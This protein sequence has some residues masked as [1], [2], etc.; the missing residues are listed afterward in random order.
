MLIVFHCQIGTIV[1]KNTD[2]EDL[3]STLS[4]EEWQRLIFLRSVGGVETPTT[5]E[6][7]MSRLPEDIISVLS[8]MA[9]IF[10]ARVWL[11]TPI[12]WA[13]RRLGV[14]LYECAV[15]FPALLYPAGSLC[16]VS[17]TARPKHASRRRRLAAG[18]A[19]GGSGR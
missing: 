4:K 18:T 6:D 10:S 11:L 1:V 14:T 3:S 8:Q 19:Y 17:V 5:E 13:D 15:P 9:P 2:R 16:G 12:G 7:A